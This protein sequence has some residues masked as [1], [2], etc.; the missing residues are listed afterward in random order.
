MQF[1]ERFA[2]FFIG[3]NGPDKLGN[4]CFIAAV[5]LAVLDLFLPN[6]TASSVLYGASFLLLSYA[7]FRSLSRNVGKRQEENRKF[8]RK[9]KRI[10]QWFRTFRSRLTDRSHAFRKCPECKSQLRLPRRKGRHTVLC[11]RC[12]CR[13]EVKI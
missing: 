10:G 4:V 12:G 7:L 2:R 3:R 1:R 5:I 9:F 11:P 8:L 13:F 6:V